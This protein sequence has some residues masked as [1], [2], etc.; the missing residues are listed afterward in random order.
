MNTDPA[1]LKAQ[2]WWVKS[3]HTHFFTLNEILPRIEFL[4]LHSRVLP[5]TLQ[6][7]RHPS[8]HPFVSIEKPALKTPTL[9]SP[10]SLSTF[11][12]HPTVTDNL[13]LANFPVRLLILSL[14]IPSA[15]HPSKLCAQFPACGIANLQH[16]TKPD[17]SPENCGSASIPQSPECSPWRP[18]VPWSATRS[19]PPSILRLKL[20][21]P[22]TLATRAA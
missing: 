7:T 19:R 1:S 22:K 2:P 12:S 11:L 14:I 4:L 21:P 5:K 8:H 3:L 17:R 9:T 18:Q 16:Q 20:I 15:S 10:T 6:F 13:L